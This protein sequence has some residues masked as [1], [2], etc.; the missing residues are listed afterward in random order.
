LRFLGN[1]RN[2]FPKNWSLLLTTSNGPC[3]DGT[4]GSREQLTHHTRERL[5]AGLI[6]YAVATSNLVDRFVWSGG[7]QICKQCKQRIASNDSCI[8]GF[9]NSVIGFELAAVTLHNISFSAHIF[10]HDIGKVCHREGS[11]MTNLPLTF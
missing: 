3:V 6:Y 2:P 11:A 7:E 1:L 4:F 5:R 8:I 10:G 9:E